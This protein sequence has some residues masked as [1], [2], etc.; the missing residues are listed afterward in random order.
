[1][2][3]A[4]PANR[5]DYAYLIG[6][7]PINPSNISM[8][9]LEFQLQRFGVVP[10]NHGA[11]LP[12]LSRYRRPN[13]KIAEWIRQ[14]VLIP[15]KRG[16]YVVGSPW[17]QGELCPPLVANHLYGPSGVSLEYAL[18]WHGLI[19]ERPHEVT[20]VTP[21]RGRRFETTLGRFS[22]TR[23]PTDLFPIGLRQESLPGGPTFLIAGPEKALCDKIVLTGNL[24][25]TSASAMRAF[26]F[27]DLRVDEDMLEGMELSVIEHYA[28]AGHKTGPLK[29]LLKVLEEAS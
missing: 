1:M 13:D 22:Y 3:G 18:A 28:S 7:F 27:E 17:R 26:L 4:L 15:L 29:A 20:S 25:I 8:H 11:L 6:Y 12:L 9:M 14:G 10:F 16:L 21:R 5:I 2:A 23:L 19:P 24:R